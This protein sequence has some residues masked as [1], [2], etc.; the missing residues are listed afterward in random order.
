MLYNGNMLS[1]SHIL[2]GILAVTT[3]VIAIKFNYQLVGLTGRQEWIESK[4]GSG[5][6]YLAFQ[7]I[8]VSLILF[9]I[10]YATGLSTPFGHWLFAPLRGVFAPG[11][12]GQ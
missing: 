11:N 12:P 3:G 6:T 8:A 2:L 4:L 1:F 10:L 5:S 9:G 7:V